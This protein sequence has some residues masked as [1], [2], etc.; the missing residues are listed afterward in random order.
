MPL[1]VACEPTP[2]AVL[3]FPL[4]KELTPVA[5]LPTPLACDWWPVAVLLKPVAREPW[6]VAVLPSLVAWELAPVAVEL[7]PEATAPIP[8]AVSPAARAG[9]KAPVVELSVTA[10]ASRKEAM[11]EILR[12]LVPLGREARK[13]LGLAC[14]VPA[15]KEIGYWDISH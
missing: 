9:V 12:A 13:P 5:V 3:L 15:W 7:P 2:G 14:C 6:P 8:V 1:P 11:A 4:A 10:W